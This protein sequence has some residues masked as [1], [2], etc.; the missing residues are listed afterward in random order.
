MDK[1]KQQMAA[2]K[3][4]QTRRLKQ[5]AQKDTQAVSTGGVVVSELALDSAAEYISTKLREDPP[6][7]YTVQQ[8]LVDGTLHTLLC[9]DGKAAT[10]TPPSQ[11]KLR[12]TCKRWKNLPQ[13]ACLAILEKISP[14]IVEWFWQQDAEVEFVPFLCYGLDVHRELYLPSKHH[15]EAWYLDSLVTACVWRHNQMGNRLASGMPR[16]TSYW[17]LDREQKALCLKVGDQIQ[18]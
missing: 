1:A 2:Q 16:D 9:G 11:R 5:Q 4:A 7:L 13:Y 10:S 12:G 17:T 15:P 18:H 14:K 6:L 8:C 3:G